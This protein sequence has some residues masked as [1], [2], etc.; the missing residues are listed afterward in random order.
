MPCMTRAILAAAL[1][2]LTAGALA[3]QSEVGLVFGRA[4]ESADTD[5]V[6]LTYRRPLEGPD[7]W[8]MP[9]HIQ[10]GASV[11]RVP[12][13]RGITRRFDVNATPIWRHHIGAAYVEAG[14]GVYF[15]TKTINNV[16]TRVP[17]S[18]EFGSHLGTGVNLGKD[19]SIG[20]GV[21]HLSN[22]GLKQPNGGINLWL[23]SGSWRF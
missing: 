14:L 3:A 9:S 10:L 5:I 18:L 2:S 13:I 12:D 23:I 15:L 6:R 1:L 8:W 21:Q 7:K 4:S 16:D 17:S 19:F 20:V 22:A 11:W